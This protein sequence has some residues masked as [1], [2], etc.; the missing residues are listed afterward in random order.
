M[1]ERKK[2]GEIK[3]FFVRKEGN[4]DKADECMEIAESAQV[5]E[6]ADE[7]MQTEETVNDPQPESM[8]EEKTDGMK[9][10]QLEKPSSK[11]S[12]FKFRER[13]VI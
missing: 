13:E 10:N 6:K 2:Q 5:E 1:K 12:S 3:A 9:E 7:P 4:S 11:L 8:T